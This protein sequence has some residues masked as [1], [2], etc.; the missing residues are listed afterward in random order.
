MRL[1][2]SCDS[3]GT[4]LLANKI[5]VFCFF[6]N[7]DTVYESSFLQGL[8]QKCP[9][10][11]LCLTRVFLC[12]GVNEKV[13]NS[14][15]FKKKQKKCESKERKWSGALVS[16]ASCRLVIRP[17]CHVGVSGG[18]E[19]GSERSKE[20]SGGRHRRNTGNARL[21]SPTALSFSCICTF[22]AGSSFV[23][24][25]KVFFP[26][27]FPFFFLLCGRGL[28]GRRAGAE[29]RGGLLAFLHRVLCARPG[30]GSGPYPLSTL[31]RFP[32]SRPSSP[33][34]NNPRHPFNSP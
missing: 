27:C 15:L 8:L 7:Y 10:V 18:T 9:K 1:K 14:L 30:L 31:S 24:D 29:G 26:C 6:L 34:L 20:A 12:C 16:E 3:A 19:E 32:D 25:L 23:S 2:I 13:V 21:T 17:M 28:G 11:S 5:K 22:S 4:L 33:P